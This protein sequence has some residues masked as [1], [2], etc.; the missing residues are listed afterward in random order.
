E[1]A[2]STTTDTPPA[3]ASD[4][5]SFHRPARLF[6]S[7]ASLAAAATVA[8]FVYAAWLLILSGGTVQW[9]GWSVV[10]GAGAEWHVSSVDP[11]GP[12]AQSLRPGDRLISMNGAPPVVRAGIYFAQHG[13]DVGEAY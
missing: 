10:S 5:A 11:H 2:S 12:A 7:F 1:H 3:V 13:L 4:S 6:V 8:S 9:L